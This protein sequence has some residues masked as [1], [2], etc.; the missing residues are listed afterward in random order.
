[1]IYY[2]DAHLNASLAIKAGIAAFLIT[3][4]EFIVGLFVNRMFHMGVWDYS[5]MRFNL[6]GQICPL[7]SLFWFF[8]AFPAFGLCRLLNLGL[9]SRMHL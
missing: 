6:L 4:A 5:G 3:F 1:M 9:F 2:I 8:L 7:F